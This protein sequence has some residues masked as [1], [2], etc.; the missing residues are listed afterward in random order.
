[1]SIPAPTRCMASAA[2]VNSRSIP[3]LDDSTA[4]NGTS[5]WDTNL[6]CPTRTNNQPNN[7]PLSLSSPPPPPPLRRP[8]SPLK[9]ASVQESLGRGPRLHA[10]LPH[11]TPHHD[12][13]INV[14]SHR[15]GNGRGLLFCGR[16]RPRMLNKNSS[17]VRARL[18]VGSMV[19]VV[20]GISASRSSVAQ[21]PGSRQPGVLLVDAPHADALC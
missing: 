15:G 12:E 1:M 17:F 18:V 10:S 9:P 16:G 3:T 11:A 19:A 4:K 7:L 21:Q 14:V 2:L 6:L 5:N 8:H 13:P 20:H